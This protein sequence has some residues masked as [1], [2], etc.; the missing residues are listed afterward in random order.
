MKAKLN[1]YKNAIGH[2]GLNSAM[3]DNSHE[4]LKPSDTRDTSNG[5]AKAWT[6]S[7]N[8]CD[9]SAESEDVHSSNENELMSFPMEKVCKLVLNRIYSSMEIFRIIQFVQVKQAKFTNESLV[10]NVEELITLLV[11][12]DSLDAFRWPHVTIDKVTQYQIKLFLNQI[13]CLILPILNNHL[14]YYY[15][16]NTPSMLFPFY[17]VIIRYFIFIY[18]CICHIY[19]FFYV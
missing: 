16:T 19:V 8:S 6:M 2:N 11:D 14:S 5:S 1:I 4:L 9:A 17:I 12:K 10:A 3:S 7:D 18:L 13:S 15:P